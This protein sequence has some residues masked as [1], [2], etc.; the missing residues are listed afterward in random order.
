[1]VIIKGSRGDRYQIK[2][3]K[4]D[5]LAGVFV[6]D[7]TID[8]IYVKYGER[9]KGLS[10]KLTDRVLLD[11]PNLKHSEIQTDLGKKY[12]ERSKLRPR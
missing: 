2:D 4:D 10:K 3:E 5:V 11:Y 12:S 7:E 6:C 8:T 9:N 1:M